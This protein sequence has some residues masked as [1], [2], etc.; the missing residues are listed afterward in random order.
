MPTYNRIVCGDLALLHKH[1]RGWVDGPLVLGAGANEA[2][3][4]ELLHDMG[5]PAGDARYRENGREQVH[6]DAQRVIHRSGVEVDIR[7]QWRSLTT[8]SSIWRDISY[9]LGM[10]LV[11]PRSRDIVRR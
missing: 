7:V 3:V 6:V 10:P 4:L 9:H 11:A 8:Y 5:S 2:I 1:V